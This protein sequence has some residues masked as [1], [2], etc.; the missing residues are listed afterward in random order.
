MVISAFIGLIGLGPASRVLP[1]V[2]R[3]L[4]S[5]NLQYIPKCPIFTTLQLQEVLTEDAS[6]SR[7]DI[8]FNPGTVPYSLPYSGPQVGTL[9][10]GNSACSARSSAIL[11]VL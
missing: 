11:S 2:G 6:Q 10:Q 8:L 5:F 7:D 1:K 9:G 4:S 3:F